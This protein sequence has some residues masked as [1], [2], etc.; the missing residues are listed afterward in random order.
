M[1]CHVGFFC[2]F[3]KEK[4]TSGWHFTESQLKSKS[5]HFE[6]GPLQDKVA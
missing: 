4:K 1:L 3:F 2:F 5:Y 6:A